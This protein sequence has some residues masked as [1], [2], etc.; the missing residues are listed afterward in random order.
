MCVWNT[1]AFKRS[2][3]KCRIDNSS[4]E[5]IIDIKTCDMVALGQTWFFGGRGTVHTSNVG[6]CIVISELDVVTI[7][8]RSRFPK[9][10]V[11]FFDA[12]LTYTKF[13]DV[14]LEMP[15]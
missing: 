2:T 11:A 15:Y 14:V 10:D 8:K 5:L 4:H 9:N 12:L 13:R 3:S 7:G 1:R 6:A